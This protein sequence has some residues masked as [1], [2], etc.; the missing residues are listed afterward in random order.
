MANK[1][2]VDFIRKE[3]KRGKSAN[4]IQRDL[5]AHHMGMRRQKLLEYV[6]K[7]KGKSAKVESQRYTPIKYRKHVFVASRKMIAV[8]G[9][10]NWQSR[11]V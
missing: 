8:Y 4:Q 11:R 5:R 6:R 3:A 10:V 9:S 2:Q 1:E 7:F